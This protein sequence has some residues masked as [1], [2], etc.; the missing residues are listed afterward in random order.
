MVLLVSGALSLGRPGDTYQTQTGIAA[1]L[2]YFITNA[3]TAHPI[4]SHFSLL[5]MM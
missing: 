2:V 1:D 4:C 5:Y 3:A